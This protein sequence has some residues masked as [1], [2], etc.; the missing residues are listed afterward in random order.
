MYLNVGVGSWLSMLGIDAKCMASVS[1]TAVVNM[2][3]LQSLLLSLCTT[4]SWFMRLMMP[5][6]AHNVLCLGKQAAV[7]AV[8]FACCVLCMLCALHAVCFACYTWHYLLC[9]EL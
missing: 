1:Q 5:L 6:C 4:C 3:V 9:T 7:H 2:V 8:Y